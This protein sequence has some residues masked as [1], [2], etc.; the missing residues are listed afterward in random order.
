V[1]KRS[2]KKVE[3]RG[4]SRTRCDIE[5]TRGATDSSEPPA[6]PRSNVAR[7][8]GL[9]LVSH[10]DQHAEQPTGSTRAH[11]ID[12]LRAPRSV[13]RACV[14]SLAI[15]STTLPTR[16]TPARCNPYGLPCITESPRQQGR[17]GLRITHASIRPARLRSRK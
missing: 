11:R 15:W 16:P 10:H 3:Q 8:L 14:G 2:K 4:R 7:V 5:T 12:T 6:S 13:D 1:A 9:L 17:P